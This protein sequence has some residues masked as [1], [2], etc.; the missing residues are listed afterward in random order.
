MNDTSGPTET[1]PCSLVSR[2]SGES[3]QPETKHHKK[4]KNIALKTCRRNVFC[5][6]PDSLVRTADMFVAYHLGRNEPGQAA[7]QSGTNTHRL[8]STAPVIKMCPHLQAKIQRREAY[9][10]LT[11]SK[12]LR[13]LIRIQHNS[14]SPTSMLILQLLPR[15]DQGSYPVNRTDTATGLSRH[16]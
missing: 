3:F 1:A 12:G 14:D 11:L 8:T 16:F 4:I 15:S 7:F 9:D 10:S 6:Y 2:D 13:H 5:S